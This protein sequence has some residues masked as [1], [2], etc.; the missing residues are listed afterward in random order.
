[1]EYK[2]KN[3]GSFRIYNTDRLCNAIKNGSVFI[4]SCFLTTKKDRK[5]IFRYCIYKN[6]EIIPSFYKVFGSDIFY[7]KLTQALNHKNDL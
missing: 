3:N 7:K 1:M 2:V 6:W 5:Q 4:D